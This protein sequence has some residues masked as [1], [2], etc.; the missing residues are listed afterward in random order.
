MRLLRLSCVLVCISISACASLDQ[1]TYEGILNSELRLAN[2]DARNILAHQRSALVFENG[3]V[4][5]TCNAY[6]HQSAQSTLI[7]STSNALAKSEYLI[8]DGLRLLGESLPAKNSMRSE[9]ERAAELVRRLDMRSFPS[10]LRMRADGA[11]YTLAQIVPDQVETDG[12]AVQVSLDGAF[13]RLEVVAE[14]RV[15]SNAD[16]DWIVWLVDEA[17]DGN[18]RNYQTLIIPDVARNPVLQAS[19]FP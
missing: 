5:S 2:R 17:T 4:A 6:L 15:D 10:S 12:N 13:L 8:C 18:Y 7:E 9:S 1:N 16:N 14:V 3:N 11:S 19:A